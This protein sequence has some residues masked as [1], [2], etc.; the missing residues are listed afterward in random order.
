MTCPN[1][2]DEN[3][4]WKTLMGTDYESPSS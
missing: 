1:L 2:L 4:D 3:I